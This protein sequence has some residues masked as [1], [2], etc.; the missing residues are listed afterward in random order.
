MKKHMQPFM[1]NCAVLSSWSSIV[2]NDP[3]FLEAAKVMGEKMTRETDKIRS[4]TKAFMRLTGRKPNNKEIS[5]L[6]ELGQEEY[7]IFK[8]NPEKKK[9]LLNAGT[10]ELDRSLDLDMVAAN[11]IVAS[12]IMNGDASI[13][14]R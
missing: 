8:A 13:T 1:D 6:L 10:Y 11:T 3:T 5:L 9:G 14:K 7:K 4:I 2:I 12:V